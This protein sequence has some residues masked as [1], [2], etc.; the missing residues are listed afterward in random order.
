LRAGGRLTIELAD[1]LTRAGVMPARC[2]DEALFHFRSFGA[3]TEL[4]DDF[5]LANDGIVERSK[6]FSGNPVLEMIFSSCLSDLIAIQKLLG[7]EETRDVSLAAGRHIPITSDLRRIGFT[8]HWIK[9]RLF[10]QY[11]NSPGETGHGFRFTG[12]EYFQDWEEFRCWLEYLS[13]QQL[14]SWESE[15]ICPSTFEGKRHLKDDC[16]DSHVIVLD[17]D[18]GELTY[19]SIHDKYPTLSHIVAASASSTPE[20]PKFRVYIQLDKPFRTRRSMLSLL[21]CSPGLSRW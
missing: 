3:S 7:D 10:R 9:D 15:L 11:P 17:H 12:D 19:D 4:G 1:W 6:L 20:H 8:Q 16:L 18:S 5:D 21:A 13:H 2:H 14:S